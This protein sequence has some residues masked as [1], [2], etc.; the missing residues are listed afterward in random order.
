MDDL[1]HLLGQK[2]KYKED[3]RAIEATYKQSSSPAVR[4][5]PHQSNWRQQHNSQGMNSG[6]FTKQ[7]ALRELI[8]QQSKI[9]LDIKARFDVNDKTLE[10]IIDKMDS[11]SSTT[12]NLFE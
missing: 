10:Y 5:V 2:A 4:K 8:M 1:L 12:N 3:Q 6:N 7:P 11:F 9:N